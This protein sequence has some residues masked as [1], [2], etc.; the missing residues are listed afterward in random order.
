MAL[1][2]NSSLASASHLAYLEEQAESERIA[3]YNRAW[4][5][6]DGESPDSLEVEVGE[7][8]DNI[9]LD[10]AKLIVD[11]GVS[12]LVGKDGG[13]VMQCEPPDSE[14]EVEAEPEPIDGE[15]PGESDDDEPSPEE[16]AREQAE[17]R[18]GEALDALDD[19]WP[20]EQRQVDFHN[21]ATNGG[22]CGHAWL[23]LSEDGSPTVL[24]PA[25][26][27]VRWNED[28]FTL[29]ERYTVQWNTIDHDD[30]MGCVRRWRIEPGDGIEPPGDA[31]PATEA[32]I[33]DPS[34][35]T[36]FEEEHNADAGRWILLDTTVWPHPF[37]P[38]LGAQNLPAPNTYY[39]LADLE[40]AVLNQ[41]EQLQS[42]ASDMRRIV[43]LH[44]HPA[45]VIFGEDATRIAALKVAIGSLIAIPNENAK[46]DQLA[47]AE[48]E[49]S[50]TL[51]EELK[52]SLFESAR[53]PKVALGDTT[54]AGPTTGVA[55]RTEYEPLI[56]KT[57][58]KRMTYGI[59]L[60]QA[61][62]CIL[63]LKG[64]EGWSVTLN[65]PEL[66]SDEEASAQNDEAELRMGIVSKQTI[67]E[68]RGYDW[69]IEQQ[70]IENEKPNFDAGTFTYTGGSY[71]G[72][73]PP[74]GAA[75]PPEEQPGEEE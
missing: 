51:Y 75:G 44:G 16:I 55:L 60:V 27:S 66:L 28:D 54:N 19:A 74:G 42:V 71:G 17:E 49:S 73:I 72:Q 20:P 33:A 23:K 50:M 29:V 69:D 14:S 2:A 9:K 4:K 43:R 26:V 6:Y 57:S 37:A 48:I 1:S 21:L 8:D 35:W 30:G 36:T 45:P 61:S 18:A 3:Q 5:A 38:I 52:T 63:A 62:E 67:S 15:E 24:D 22:V 13:V 7:A 53:I 40:P 56:E 39:G 47:I 12:F 11:K 32:E 31:E 41:V 70:R 68:Q 46:L 25:N 34:Y 58:T 65:W 59:L 10:Y 64:Y